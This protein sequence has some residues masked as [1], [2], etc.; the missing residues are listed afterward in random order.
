MRQ[1]ITIRFSQENLRLVN[2]AIGDS[3]ALAK[4]NYTF[5]EKEEYKEYYTK[6]ESI[7]TGLR[8]YI[9]DSKRG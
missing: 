4:R 9:N 6:L 5:T 3:M 1:I 8:I 2:S 7:L